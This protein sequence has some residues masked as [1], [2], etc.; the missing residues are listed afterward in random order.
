RAALAERSYARA[1]AWWVARLAE[2]LEH[3]HDRG[4]LHRDIKPSNVLVNDDGMPMLLDFNLAR[5][6]VLA[7]DEQGEAA[8]AT[9]GG[10]VDY[11]APEHLESLAEGF[12]DR[13]DRRS[14]IYGL[15]VLLYEAIVGKKPFLPPRKTHSVI[16]SLLRAADERRHDP[17]IL[18]TG[19]VD[20]PAALRSWVPTSTISLNGTSGSRRFAASIRQPVRPSTRTTSRKPRSCSTTPPRGPAIPSSAR[21]TTC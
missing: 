3:A 8:E 19:D 11:M 20:V 2:A 12:S 5:E 4:V 16:D 13:V 10:T 9:L 21:F 7:E 14:D 15:G 18:F 6:S 1:I 17:G